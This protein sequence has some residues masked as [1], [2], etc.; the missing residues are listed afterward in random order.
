MNGKYLKHHIMPS[1][2]NITLKIHP[3]ASSA[4]LNE[5]LNQCEVKIK[6]IMTRKQKK[7]LTYDILDTPSSYEERLQVLKVTQKQMKKGEIWQHMIGTF[8]GFIDLK[9][10]HTSGLD[11]VSHTRKIAIELKSRTNTDNSESYST[12]IRKLVKFKKDNPDYLCIYANINDATEAK[13]MRGSVTVKY[14]NGVQIE[15]HVGMQFLLF[16]FGK[17]TQRIIDFIKTNIDKY[18]YD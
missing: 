4:Y 2:I 1:H 7:T 13:T 8:R 10:G 18:K 17:D 14:H 16:I 3:S 11:I 12:K 6:E 5:Y 9:K 15:H